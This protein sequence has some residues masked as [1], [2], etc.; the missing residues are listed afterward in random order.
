MHTLHIQ[1]GI[2]LKTVFSI[3][4]LLYMRYNMQIQFILL[5]LFFGIKIN[6]NSVKMSL[7]VYD[8]RS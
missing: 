4:V 8:H 5:N 3:F 6:R 2:I 1:L 7:E